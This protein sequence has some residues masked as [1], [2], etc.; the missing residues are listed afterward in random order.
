[1]YVM[2]FSKM[3]VLNFDLQISA[4]R[5]AVHNSSVAQKNSAMEGN[6]DVQTVVKG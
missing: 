6:S 5:V 1:M 4:Y 3:E 2:K